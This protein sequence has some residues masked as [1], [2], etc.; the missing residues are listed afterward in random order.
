MLATTEV[1]VDEDVTC[2]GYY[3]GLTYV[4]DDVD[5]MEDNFFMLSENGQERLAHIEE[6]FE[7]SSD[8]VTPWKILSVLFGSINVNGAENRL[9]NSMKRFIQPCMESA[10]RLIQKPVE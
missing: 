9:L 10:A 6:V 7:G 1:V 4:F 3:E 2:D 5:P 8:R